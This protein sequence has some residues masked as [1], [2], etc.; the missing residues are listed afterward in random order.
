MPG[1]KY[2]IQNH[3]HTNTTGKYKQ[4]Y[5][6]KLPVTSKITCQKKISISKNIS[7]YNLPVGNEQFHQT[8]LMLYEVQTSHSAISLP[9]Y[10]IGSVIKE[11]T[12]QNPSVI[13]EKFYQTNFCNI[14]KILNVYK[15]NLQFHI[16]F[17][18]ILIYGYLKKGNVNKHRT[19]LV[20]VS[21]MWVICNKKKMR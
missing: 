8:F 20:K 11:V 13:K 6:R 15:P 7:A 16:T 19:V 10:K 18:Q 1:K 2:I 4:N 12:V 9:T 3:I 17:K 21:L 14:L 5:Q